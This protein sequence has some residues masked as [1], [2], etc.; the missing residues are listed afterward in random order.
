MPSDSVQDSLWRFVGR[1]VRFGGGG[2]EIV[3]SWVMLLKV[4]FVLAILVI[5][6]N[7]L[8]AFSKDGHA[9]QA[10]Q[11]RPAKA[12]SKTTG[13]PIRAIPWMNHTYDFGEEGTCAVSNGDYSY[14]DENGQVAAWLHIR[15]VTF[16]DI[17]SHGQEEALV[18][19]AGGAGGVA[20]ILSG[21]IYGLKD[22]APVL[23]AAVESGDRGDNGIQSMKVK[24]GDVIVRRFQ[25]DDSAPDAVGSCCPNRI[26]I[27]RWHW[28]EGTLV[29]VGQTKALHRIPKPWSGIRRR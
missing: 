13:S 17:D 20:V 23:L 16:G 14:L 7:P 28:S 29:R 21:Y 22:G 1:D 11:S 5:V 18:T 26:E 3:G 12:H 25:A 2:H 9:S 24:D 8:P 10:R 15:A 4:A 6:L 19:T 27:E